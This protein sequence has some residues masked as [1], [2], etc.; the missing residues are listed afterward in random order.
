MTIEL[1]EYKCPTCGHHL[2]QEEYR[3]VCDKNES[4]VKQLVEER[5]QQSEI[6]H[7]KEMQQSQFNHR[8]EMQ[9]LQEKHHI[10]MKEE[11]SIRVNERLIQERMSI[12]LKHKQEL[13]EKDEENKRALANNNSRHIQKEKELELKLKRVQDQLEKQ[14]TTS[15]LRGTA[16]EFVLLELLQKE[17]PTDYFTPKR[18]GVSMADVVHTIVT[19]KGERIPTPIVYDVKMGETVTK[20]DLAKAKNYMSIHNTPHSIIVTKNIKNERY[21]EVREGI[22]LVHPLA[23]TDITH[24]IRKSLIETRILIKNNTGR[25][26]KQSKLYDHFTSQEYTRYIQRR[27]ELKMNLDNLD[28][29]EEDER[30]KIRKKRNDT[31]EEWY[32]LDN[33]NDEI[34]MD[35]TQDDT[36]IQIQTLSD[37]GQHV[38]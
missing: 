13:A 10:E 36:D 37:F 19:E 28:R 12:D 24:Q 11:V 27:I 14:G 9:G 7:R 29:K 1:Q 2:G 30:R 16:G 4:H 33:R 38:P 18:T 34:I 25:D 20:S 22:L 17:F 8:K 26:S 15:E 31:I 23:L 21:T 6:N 32:D 35:I 5:L 3:K